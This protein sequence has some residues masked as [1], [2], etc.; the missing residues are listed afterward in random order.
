MKFEPEVKEDMPRFIC[1]FSISALLVLVPIALILYLW[2]RPL[3]TLCGEY[4]YGSNIAYMLLSFFTAILGLDLCGRV[5]ALFFKRNDFYR[6]I[7][8]IIHY[9]SLFSFPIKIMFIILV[10]TAK[11]LQLLL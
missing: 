6:K 2:L 1:W 7:L 11:T 3:M 5:F 8:P 9:Y 10:I 4:D